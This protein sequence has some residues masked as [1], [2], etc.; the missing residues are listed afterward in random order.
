VQDGKPADANA[1][2]SAG[3]GDPDTEA[4]RNIGPCHICVLYSG[5]NSCSVLHS[6]LAAKIAQ[7]NRARTAQNSEDAFD[8][9]RLADPR[10]GTKR[11]WFIGV[12]IRS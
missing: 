10:I 2:L 1:A 9:A 7:E 5:V 4:A 8:R 3:W 12:P 6:G 11:A